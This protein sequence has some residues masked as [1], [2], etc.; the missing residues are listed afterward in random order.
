VHAP[1]APGVIVPIGVR[2]VRPLHPG[3]VHTV[4]VERG[5]VAVDGERELEFGP[6]TPVTIT[7][8]ADGPRI[9]DVRNVLAAAAERRL[10]VSELHQLS[11]DPMTEEIR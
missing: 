5:T 11:L 9:L 4:A 7:L 1:I 8:A 10:L 3:D 2:D 6:Q